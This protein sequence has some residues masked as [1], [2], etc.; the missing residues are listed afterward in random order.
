MNWVLIR[1]LMASV[2][3]RVLFPMQDVLGLGSEARMNTPSVPSGNWRWRMPERAG[4]RAGSRLREM[5]ELYGRVG[6]STVAAD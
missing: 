6:L 1:A 2:A 4:A 3:N 5:A